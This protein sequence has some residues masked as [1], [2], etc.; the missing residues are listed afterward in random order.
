M[1]KKK[2]KVEPRKKPE[3]KA[4]AFQVSGTFSFVNPDLIP[5]LDANDC[6]LGLKTKDGRTIRLVVAL[7]IENKEET[8][9]EYAVTTADMDKVGMEGLDYETTS[10]IEEG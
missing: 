2:T 3:P 10:L 6:I 1:A 8:G 7:E 9:C 4:Y 5:V